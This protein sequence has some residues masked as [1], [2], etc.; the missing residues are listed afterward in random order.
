MTVHVVAGLLQRDNTL[1]IAERPPGKPYSGYWE[2]PG[3]KIEPNEKSEHALKRELHEELGIEVISSRHLFTH[4]YSYPDKHVILEV[5]LVEE[6]SGEPYGKENQELRW[7]THEEMLQLP[8]LEG[9]WPIIE[10]VTS[11]L[12]KRNTHGKSIS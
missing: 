8:M 6:F 10:K 1:L 7:L 5:W 11:K 4:H 9:N 12:K 3:G 2:F